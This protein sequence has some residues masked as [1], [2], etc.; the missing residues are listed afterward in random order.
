MRKF[1]AEQEKAGLIKPQEELSQATIE[2]QPVP[3]PAL[4]VT[5]RGD[6]EAAMGLKIS[7]GRA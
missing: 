3:P 2:P 6:P 5:V 7:R 1:L 4:L